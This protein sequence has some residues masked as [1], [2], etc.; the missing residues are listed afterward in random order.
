MHLVGCGRGKKAVVPLF[1]SDDSAFRF[2][3]RFLKEDGHTTL[4]SPASGVEFNAVGDSLELFLKSGNSPYNY[5]SL[6]VDGRYRGRYQINGDS[7]NRIAIALPAGRSESHEIALYKEREAS[8]GS[9]LF[10]GAKTEKITSAKVKRKTKIE[11]IGDSIT[12]GM[13]ADLTTVPCGK[14]EWFDQHNA[15]FAFGP[16]VAR[17]LNADYLLSSVSGIGMYRNWNDENLEEPIMPEV[18]DNLFLN[19]DS[20]YQYT[21]DHVPDIICICL[22]TNDMSE[23]D[24]SKPRLP[25]SRKMFVTSCIAFTEHLF[26]IHP[27]TQ[28]VLLNS[29]MV[30]GDKGN[31]LLESLQ[32]IKDH[33]QDTRKV[34]IFQFG[35]MSPNGCTSHPSVEVHKVMAYQLRPFL[36]QIL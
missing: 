18:Y 16:R 7:I 34:S 29:P 12:C 8:N 13:G 20:A 31:V 19:S 6:S 22:G 1:E 35:E 28:L 27:N 33:Y 24:G 10:Y 23:G 9:I 26:G 21:F 32:E 14:G 3:G 30:S 2:Q 15:Y 11:F 4:I 17:A 5:F 25:F 36:K